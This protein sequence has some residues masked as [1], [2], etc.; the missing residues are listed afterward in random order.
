MKW[1]EVR[2]I[3]PYKWVVYES[4]SQYEED[5]MLIVTDLAIIDVFD[6]I[7]EAYKFYCKMHK[8][9][10]SIKLSI[11]DTRQNELSYEIERVGLYKMGCSKKKISQ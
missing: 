1:N 11:G 6:N 2:K 5:N 7:N 4:L 9:N 8:E 3:Y 10:K